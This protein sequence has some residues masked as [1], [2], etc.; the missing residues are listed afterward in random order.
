M[1]SGLMFHMMS[2]LGLTQKV[3]LD[4]WEKMISESSE[5]GSDVNI[6]ENANVWSLSQLRDGVNISAGVVI[7]RGVYIGEGVTIGAYS[8]IQNYALIYEPAE[9]G[10]GVFI[11]PSAVLT[12]DLWPRAINPDGTP[13]SSTDWEPVGVKVQLGASI[14][15]KAVCVAPVTI[16][17]WSM[18]AAGAVVIHDVPDFALVAGVPA[19]RVGWVGK[20]GKRLIRVSGS[21]DTWICPDTAMTFK[22]ISQEHLVASEPSSD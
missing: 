13:K 15:A 3:F 16:G 12:N 10:T 6:S 22:E 19:R 14:G 1:L 17:A 2:S 20:S 4:D 21:N 8:K 5:I 9:I 7:G 11:G 18:I